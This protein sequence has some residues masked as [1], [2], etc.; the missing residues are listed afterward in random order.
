MLKSVKVA[1]LI[2]PPTGLYDRFERCQSPV[3][4]ESVRIIRPPLDLMYLASI[5]ERNNI[6]VHIRDYPAERKDWRSVSRDIE[7]ICPDL[8]L[9]SSTLPTYKKDCLSSKIAKKVNSSMVCVLKGFFPDGGRKVLLDYPEIDIVLREDPEFALEEFIQGKSL[10]RIKG[11]SYRN[12]QKVVIVNENRDLLPDLD[13]L[14]FPTRHLINN[15]LYRM[16]DNGKKIDLIL[17]AKGC[18]F[19]CIFCLVPKTNGG[20]LRLRS[21]AS[22]IAELEECVYKYNI[23]N[24][25]FRADT[26]TINKIWVIDIC[27]KIIERKLNIRWATNSRVDTIDEEMVSIMKKSGCF[28]LGFGLESG[29]EETLKRIKKKTAK[30]QAKRAVDLCRRHGIQ[31][32]LF[33]IIGFPWETIDHIKD[34]I[35]F[36]KDLN[37]DIFNFSLATPFPGTELFDLSLRLGLLDGEIDYSGRD[38]SNPLI[39]TLYLDR[40]QLIKIEKLA[41]RQIILRP[42]YVLRSIRNIKS[43]AM[44]LFYLKSACHLFRLFI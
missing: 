31:S 9:V 30:Q 16:P 24:F 37:G 38:Y 3:D 34:T 5:L 43:P 27:K 19:E 14:P 25:W 22:L 18:P 8:L 15:N 20:R 17:T 1:L 39:G 21:P 2:N 6:K 7:G 23:T 26:F 33:F 32:Y 28:A 40:E 10:D 11:L 13:L 4:S 42:S 36:A 41:Y 35:N 29:N 44:A 12:A